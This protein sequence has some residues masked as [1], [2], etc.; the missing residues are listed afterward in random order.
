M[1]NNPLVGRWKSDDLSME[2]TP[3]GDLVYTTF[4]S[5][6]ITGRILL[7]YRIE[8]QSLVTDQL[9][10]PREERTLFRVD[11]DQLMLGEATNNKVLL[12]EAPEASSDPDAYMLAIGS[13]AIGHALASVH[14]DG[15]FTPFL[16]TDNLQGRSLIRF[17]AS[18]PEN[19]R[20]EAEK[21]TVAARG[22]IIA[23]AY[24][25]DGYAALE[26]G[27]FDAVLAEVSQNFHGDGLLLVQPYRLERNLA[28][29]AG[30][31]VMQANRSWLQ[32]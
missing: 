13:F 3:H 15:P 29:R 21:H 5:G 24:I 19:A 1:T 22:Q 16:V 6:Q 8:G 31:M 12:R 4:E 17:V 9:S 11:G 2:F 20:A 23:C 27:R 26:N 7:V 10:S 28:R 32:P 25:S 14:P 18:S 30:R